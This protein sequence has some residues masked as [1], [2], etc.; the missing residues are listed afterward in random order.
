MYVVATK[1]HKIILNFCIVNG[2]NGGRKFYC[3]WK[4][5]RIDSSYFFSVG[6]KETKVEN[7]LAKQRQKCKYFEGGLEFI[8]F[9]YLFF[10]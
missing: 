4:I 2:M 1:M 10:F 8:L 3:N 5:K 9:K 7:F 6:M